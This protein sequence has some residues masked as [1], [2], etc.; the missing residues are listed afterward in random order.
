[1]KLKLINM[2][3]VNKLYSWS[4]GTVAYMSYGLVHT[5]GSEA[6]VIPAGS[7]PHQQ[8]S[9]CMPVATGSNISAGEMQL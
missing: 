7:A 1:M 3:I 5:C 6:S 8:I 2:L 4:G 9:T